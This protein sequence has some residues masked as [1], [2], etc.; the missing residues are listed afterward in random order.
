VN[1]VNGIV[2]MV[3]VLLLMAPLPLVPFANTLPAIAIILLCLGM[4]ERDGVLILAGYVLSVVSAA[5]VSGILW[6]AAKTGSNIDDAW[7]ALTEMLA[8]TFGTG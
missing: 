5:Y 8:R 1:S 2:L 7:R 3:S 6:L 4:A